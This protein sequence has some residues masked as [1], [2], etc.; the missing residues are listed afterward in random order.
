M[1]AFRSL[2]PRAR[3]VQ[4]HMITEEEERWARAGKC[5]RGLKAYWVC[6]GW[7]VVT[8]LRA[9]GVPHGRQQFFDGDG[10]AGELAQP[11]LHSGA[12]GFTQNSFV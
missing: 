11:H 6:W 7:C 9:L 8:H 2:S 12:L 10:D 1:R 4:H 5:G 3:A